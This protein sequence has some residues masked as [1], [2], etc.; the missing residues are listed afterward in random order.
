MAAHSV[1]LR[2]HAFH[3]Q[4]YAPCPRDQQLQGLLVKGMTSGCEHESSLFVAAVPQDEAEEKAKH[5]GKDESGPVVR[6]I[7]GI[8]LPEPAQHRCRHYQDAREML[9]NLVASR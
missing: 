6:Y 1:I 3:M 2:L 4:R 5:S 8:A 9:R 7:A